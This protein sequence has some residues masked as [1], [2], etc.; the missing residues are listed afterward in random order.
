MHEVSIRIFARHRASARRGRLILAVRPILERA[1][2]SAALPAIGRETVG[3]PP[4]LWPA[5]RFVFGRRP[6]AS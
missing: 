6:Q 5:V 3:P 4:L 2:P 1:W